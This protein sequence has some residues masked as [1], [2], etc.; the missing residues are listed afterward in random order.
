MCT[1]QELFV[2]R[3]PWMLLQILMLSIGVLLCSCL[4]T[5]LRSSLMNLII[6]MNHSRIAQVAPR[7]V[8]G[9]PWH[10]SLPTGIPKDSF[11]R[12]LLLGGCG[13]VLPE[14]SIAHWCH[15]DIVALNKFQGLPKTSLRL[16]VT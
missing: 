8:L 13:V 12:L 15:Q 6:S 2:K 7:G 10:E 4:A 1:L 5:S 9:A 3:L 14:F 11:D 16:S